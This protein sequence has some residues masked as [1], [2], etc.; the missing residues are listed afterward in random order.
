MDPASILFAAAAA[1]AAQAPVRPIRLETGPV[2]GA[3]L[4]SVIGESPVACS[5]RYRLEVTAGTAGSA[6]RSVQSGVAQ[7]QPRRRVTLVNLRLAGQGSR[8]VSAILNVESC[9]GQAY[10]Q[11][12]TSPD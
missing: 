7:L 4:L 5:A 3:E 2:A 10:Q 12:W 1:N 8:Q 6:N 9:G 11:I